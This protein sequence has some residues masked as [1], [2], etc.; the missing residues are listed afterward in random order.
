MGT[1]ARINVQDGNQI[2]VSIYRQFDGYPDGLGQEILDQFRGCQI[3]N[4]IGP[5]DCGQTANGMGCFAAQLVAHLKKDPGN[6][7]LRN[8]GDD[9]QG[10]EFSYNLSERDG[11]LWLSVGAGCVTYFGMPGDKETKMETI[12]NGP[13]ADFDP[14][15]A[16]AA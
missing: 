7:Y 5:G 13:L 9:S 6:V 15:K 10:E 4:G 16:A 1:R 14:G 3:T 8:T 11:K 12:Y 2:I